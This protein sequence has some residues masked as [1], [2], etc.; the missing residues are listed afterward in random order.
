MVKELVLSGDIGGT[1]ANLGIVELGFKPKVIS[2]EKKDTKNIKDFDSFIVGYIEELFNIRKIKINRACFAVAGPV[3]DNKIKMTNTPL[4]VDG[5]IIKKKAKLKQAL[6]INDFLAIG[7]AINIIG[8]KDLKVLQ[9]GK[10]EEEGAKAVIGA[11][12]GLGHAILRYDKGKENYIPY[13]TERGHVA[14]PIQDDEELELAK[15]IRS[16]T[17][18]KTVIYEDILSGHGIEHLYYYLNSKK[19]QDAPHIYSPEISQTRSKNKCSKAAFELFVHFYARAARS[20]ALTVLPSAGVYIA[21]GIA[22]DNSDAFGK[23]FINEFNT[24]DTYSSLLKQI[25]I[26]LINN[27]DISIPGAALALMLD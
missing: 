25:P 19:Y 4:S 6:L 14:F 9:K 12:T 22:I 21:G 26:Y 7:Y 1:H 17:K 8:K 23:D 27:Y 5:N 20:F 16:T 24:H 15:F 3:K 10:P 2:I 13:P 18:K 11:G